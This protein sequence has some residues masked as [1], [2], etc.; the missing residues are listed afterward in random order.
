M[1]NL[2]KLVSYQIFHDLLYLELLAKVKINR[3][4][5][6]ILLIKSPVPGTKP[7]TIIRASECLTTVPLI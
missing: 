1:Q 4:A 7:G 2:Q 6:E 5:P 3:Q